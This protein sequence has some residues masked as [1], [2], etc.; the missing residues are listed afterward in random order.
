MFNLILI[1]LFFYLFLRFS[2]FSALPLS[3]QLLLKQPNLE[4][5]Q[6]FISANQFAVTLFLLY[7]TFNTLTEILNI[8]V[9]KLIGTPSKKKNSED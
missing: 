2:L 4:T 1:L 9:L 5:L 3:F 6:Y 7:V 8:L